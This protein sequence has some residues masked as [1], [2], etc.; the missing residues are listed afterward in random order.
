MSIK[1]TVDTLYNGGVSE[2]ILQELNKV[3]E[4]VA[5]P[6]TPAKKKR[7]VTLKLEITPNEQRNLASMKVATSST[8]CAPEPIETS[9]AIVQNSK[10]GEMYCEEI[11]ANENFNQH[12]FPDTNNIGKVASANDTT[13]T[14]NN[15]FNDYQ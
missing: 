7:T 5:D 10:T 12:S 11:I 2:R 8:L 1:L 3:I 9:I 14:P 15:T 6:N 13:Y 4:N